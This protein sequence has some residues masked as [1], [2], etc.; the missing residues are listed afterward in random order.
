[1]LERIDQ[2]PSESGNF[3]YEVSLKRDHEDCF[4]E[5][6]KAALQKP[7]R[8]QRLASIFIE[9]MGYTHQ[10]IFKELSEHRLSSAVPPE[11]QEL[12]GKALVF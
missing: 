8:T 3:G 2:D 9:K 10:Q 1:M 11:G 6:L 7:K 5:T 4:S 12:I